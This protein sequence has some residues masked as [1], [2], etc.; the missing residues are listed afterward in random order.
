MS[1]GRSSPQMGVL[2]LG[3][4]RLSARRSFLPPTGRYP[5]N[6]IP[7]LSCPRC[8]LG[9]IFWWGK[10]V[11]VLDAPAPHY[12]CY[13]CLLVFHIPFPRVVNMVKLWRSP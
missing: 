11:W 8:N 9:A 4:W 2:T 1:Q 6:V 13:N 12:Y 5:D 3:F 10:P 7:E